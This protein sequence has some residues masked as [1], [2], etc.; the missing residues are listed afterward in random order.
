MKTPA[1]TVIGIGDDGCSSLSTVAYNHIQQC[2]VLVGGER[3]LGFFSDFPGEKIVLKSPMLNQLKELVP[4]SGEEQMVI[5]ASGDPLFYGIGAL[6]SRLFGPEHVQVLPHVS[7]M[8]LAFAAVGLSWQKAHLESIHGRSMQ[9]LVARLQLCET[10]GLFTDEDNSPQRVAMTLKEYGDDNWELFVCENLG[11]RDER[12][13]RFTV[14]ELAATDA[15]SPLNVLILKRLTPQPLPPVI[16]DTPDED[17]A[18][19]L[20]LKGLITKQEIRFLTLAK[21]RL[22]PDS[23]MWDVGAASGAIAIEAAKLAPNGRVF[24]IECNPES[25]EHCEQNALTHR[26]DHLTTVAGQAPAALSDLPAPDAVFIGGSKGQL[27]AIIEQSYQALKPGG[28]LVANAVT[29]ENVAEIQ[30]CCKRLGLK[31]EMTLVQISRGKDLAGR[32]LR[33]EA[34]NPIHMFTLEKT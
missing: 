17:Y 30:Q 33:Y 6:V 22:R 15:V 12:V 18:R 14:D 20:P 28:R 34:L 7:S 27:D 10:A 31:P 4:R 3:Q 11:G 32:Y 8:Q 2:Q 5:L 9:G 21:L 19:R 26:V 16:P 24:A 25:V 13:R 23:V 1:V 29:V